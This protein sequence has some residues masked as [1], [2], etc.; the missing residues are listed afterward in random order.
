MR[1]GN[2]FFA[3]FLPYHRIGET[4]RTRQSLTQFIHRILSFDPDGSRCDAFDSVDTN[5]KILQYRINVD[6]LSF[7]RQQKKNK[8]TKPNYTQFLGTSETFGAIH[9]SVYGACST[10]CQCLWL[11]CGITNIV[12]AAL[13]SVCMSLPHYFSLTLP[14]YYVSSVLVVCSKCVRC[15]VANEEGSM[16]LAA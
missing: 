5:M 6:E 9:I 16:N 7:P 8:K 12:G 10:H 4:G 11:S 2:I 3:L 1:F 14:L 15:C 13:P